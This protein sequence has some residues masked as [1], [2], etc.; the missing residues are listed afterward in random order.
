M[1]ESDVARLTA[2]WACA[3]DSP[4]HCITCSDEALEACVIE[5]EGDTALVGLSESEIWAAI[6]ISLLDVV[7]PGNRLLIHGGVALEIL[8]S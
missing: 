7:V 8:S 2:G 3:P 1:L 5:V 4:G 6:D